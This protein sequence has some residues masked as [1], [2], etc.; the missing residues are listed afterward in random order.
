MHER[1]RWQLIL[2]LL[3]RQP[4]ATVAEIA[5]LTESSTATARRDIAKLAEKGLVTRVHGGAEARPAPSAD[6]QGL[7]AQPFLAGQALH[8]GRKRAIAAAAAALCSDGDSII[9]N[10]GTTTFGMVEFIADRQM[11]ILTNSFPLAEALMRSGGNRILL[12]GGQVYREQGLILSP[13]D[14]DSLRHHFASIMFMGAQGIVPHGL[15]EGDPLLIRAEQKLLD[16]AERLVVLVDSSKFRS[17]GGL[18]L[19]PL[20]RIHTI[21]TDDGI[22]P[23]A[24]AMCREAGVAVQVVPVQCAEATSPRPATSAA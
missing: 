21:I 4:I 13:Y 9:I 2:A 16:R 12:P 19:C 3:G 20:E 7:A 22:D 6:A 8:H 10:G 11:Q 17:R 15:M 23:A 18:I 14:D 1:R 24:L 5:A